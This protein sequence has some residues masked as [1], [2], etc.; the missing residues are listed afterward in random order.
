MKNLMT[1]FRAIVTFTVLTGVLYPLSVTFLGQA[2]LSEKSGGS[3]VRREGAVAGSELIAQG[4]AQPKYFWPRPSAVKY[5]CASSGAS[6]L[7][8]SST[9]LLKAFQE[10]E[11]LGTVGEMRF[12]S[13]SGLDPHIS[14]E[15]TRSQVTRIVDSRKL[16]A[17]QAEVLAKLIVAHTEPRQ[18]GFLGEPRVNVLKLNL[19]LDERFGK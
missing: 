8:V 4:F 9:D 11:A 18:F 1:S 12:S 2:F 6:N 13:G 7:S 3:L 5:D 14:A 10:R 17:G 15:A 16:S 19:E